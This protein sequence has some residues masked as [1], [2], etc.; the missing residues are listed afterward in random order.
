MFKAMFALLWV[1]AWA[2]SA[3]QL[4]VVPLSSGDSVLPAV[5]GFGNTTVASREV[6]A[7]V[8]YPSGRSARASIVVAFNAATGL[9]MWHFSAVDKGETDPVRCPASFVEMQSTLWNQTG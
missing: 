9:Y 8:V 5:N 1:S 6:Y 7:D 3:Q 2:A 4:E